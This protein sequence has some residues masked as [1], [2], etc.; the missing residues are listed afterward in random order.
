MSLRGDSCAGSLVELHQHATGFH[1]GGRTDRLPTTKAALCV[2]DTYAALSEPPSALV[3]HSAIV[4]I[5]NV[6]IAV[7]ST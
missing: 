3:S 2:D 1:V 7:W 6:V 5:P 4:D